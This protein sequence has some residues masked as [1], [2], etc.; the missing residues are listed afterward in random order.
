[1][2]VP[3]PKIGAAILLRPTQ[4]LSMY[5]QQ[6]GRALRPFPGKTCAIIL[7]H[8]GS[9]IKFGMIDEPR[10]WTLQG[11]VEKR[12][13]KPAPSVRVCSKCFSAALSFSIS[14]RTTLMPGF[15]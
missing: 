15:S 11:D 2:W 5:L 14:F 1:M 3:G 8:V 12:K 4:S 6:V 7:D 13:K 10:E 9:T